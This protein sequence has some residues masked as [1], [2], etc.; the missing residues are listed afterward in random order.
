LAT[1]GTQ[2]SNRDDES[3]RGRRTGGA[4]AGGREVDTPANDR[5]CRNKRHG[6]EEEVPDA[7]AMTEKDTVGV[8]TVAAGWEDEDNETG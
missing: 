3:E 6:E 4:V 1:G 2:Q 7:M 5:R 8:G